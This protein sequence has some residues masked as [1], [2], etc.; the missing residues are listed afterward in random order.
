MTASFFFT[1]LDLLDDYGA[2]AA[3]ISGDAYGP[4]S[5]TQFRLNSKHKS[6][7]A[8]APKAYAVAKGHVLIHPIPGD[9]AHVNLILKPIDQP[10][11]NKGIGLPR[12]KYLIYRQVLKA[13]LI[14][15]GSSPATFVPAG[16]IDMID[17]I[18]STYR[19]KGN[20][21]V[22]VDNFLTSGAPTDL[23]V[24]AFSAKSLPPILTG[25]SIGR[26]D[27]S[28]FSFEVLLDDLG[29]E[30][31]LTLASRNHDVDCIC[32]V[33][34]GSS[35]NAD[36]FTA[37]AKREYVLH[38]MDP[39]AFYGNC[40]LTGLD[41]KKSDGTKVSVNGSNPTKRNALYPIVSKFYNRERAYVD[42]R[43]ENGYS[44]NY[45]CFVDDPVKKN[46]FSIY[47]DQIDLAYIND[48]GT[49]PSPATDYYDSG[50]WPL[51]IV[52]NSRFPP[53]NKKEKNILS[54]RMPSGNNTNATLFFALGIRNEGGVDQP[55]DLRTAVGSPAFVDLPLQPSATAYDSFELVIPN[56]KDAGTTTIIPT[57]S[58][59][60]YIR[61]V[62]PVDLFTEPTA[63]DLQYLDNLFAPALLRDK[64]GGAR[65]STYENEQYVDLTNGDQITKMEYIGNTQIE[66]GASNVTLG[67]YPVYERRRNAGTKPN[68]TIDT[69]LR[70][71]TLE[72]HLSAA[73]AP[74]DVRKPPFVTESLTLPPF[75]PKIA[76]YDRKPML[77]PRWLS[78]DD[79]AGVVLLTIDRNNFQTKVIDAI[80]GPNAASTFSPGFDVYLCIKSQ[81]HRD[82]DDSN[83]ADMSNP[84]IGISQCS[85]FLRGFKL[86]SGNVKVVEVDT[87]IRLYA[88]REPGFTIHTFLRDGD[89]VLQGTSA[90]Q[91][92]SCSFN[93]TD[94]PPASPA[95]LGEE[96]N[97]IS[98]DDMK[99][100]I[101]AL[102]AASSGD[103]ASARLYRYVFSKFIKTKSTPNAKGVFEPEDPDNIELTFSGGALSSAGHPM[104]QGMLLEAANYFTIWKITQGLQRIT[105]KLD[106]THLFDSDTYEGKV[107][108]LTDVLNFLTA[109]YPFF[110]NMVEGLK[111]AAVRSPIQII[112]VDR[113]RKLDLTSVKAFFT[114]IFRDN[115]G[116]SAL[117]AA[118]RTYVQTHDQPG[119]ILSAAKA[120]DALDALDATKQLYVNSMTRCVY[121]GLGGI[122]TEY[123]LLNV[124]IGDGTTTLGLF[125]QGGN[126]SAGPGVFLFH[127]FYDD[128]AQPLR[129]V[130]LTPQPISDGNDH[131]FEVHFGIYGIDNES[132]VK[133][134]ISILNRNGER[135]EGINPVDG[136]KVDAFP[137][138]GESPKSFKSKVPAATGLASWN[139]FTKDLVIEKPMSNGYRSVGISLDSKTDEQTFSIALYKTAGITGGVPFAKSF[140]NLFADD[141]FVL[142]AAK[143]DALW[144]VSEIES[145]KNIVQA[146]GGNATLKLQ[147]MVGGGIGRK[148]A[149]NSVANYTAG[150]RYPEGTLVA[151]NGQFYL[152]LENIAANS[153]FDPAKWLP[154]PAVETDPDFVFAPPASNSPNDPWPRVR[155]DDLQKPAAGSQQETDYAQLRYSYASIIFDSISN[156][157]RISVESYASPLFSRLDESR[158][159]AFEDGSVLAGL[160]P[161]QQTCLTDSTI[162]KQNINS[163]AYVKGAPPAPGE[164]VRDAY[165]PLLSALRCCGLLNALLERIK[166]EAFDDDSTVFN[167]VAPKIDAFKND[168]SVKVNLTPQGPGV[169]KTD[170][171]L[172]K[173]TKIVNNNCP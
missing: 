79:F 18:R 76:Y 135:A 57:Y 6:N 40:Y 148:K 100:F 164:T 122:L 125:G 70:A 56:N 19:G 155:E 169:L 104:H 5:G 159:V 64:T 116:S 23:I 62:A 85:L 73:G 96:L 162:Y 25:A 163:Q 132:T 173:F 78:N 111:A 166:L 11:E 30:P 27:P 107:N 35:S 65:P 160:T 127:Y 13:S 172:I 75:H 151:Y 7:S 22:P 140:E 145:L 92:Y 131:A 51:L 149:T 32:T 24:D 102:Y 165:N 94:P 139:N 115:H 44:F 10:A 43:N 106:D 98:N 168:P 38:F 29:F 130:T 16:T 21:E 67:C 86:D 50:G 93:V 120:K 53:N 133:H 156:E 83:D 52:K 171:N 12:I 37:R 108:K 141:A 74:A 9:D 113:T 63:T 36:Q 26:F 80:K 110:N 81:S 59:V 46:L 117:V 161:N 118:L 121:E 88:K 124:A 54:V 34:Q 128:A 112:Q 158:T 87:Q 89:A 144:D 61:R 99:A 123:T 45:Y 84:A 58:L 152:S 109:Q 39:C 68:P 105:K 101:K 143:Q 28:G 114:N 15:V 103:A 20:S 60:K 42:I 129:R 31:D 90:L 71:A 119:T 136:E 55:I 41:A 134:V 167:R 49:N 8:V 95:T 150:A 72:R 154:Q 69:E 2:S 97:N 17:T 33:P 91:A 170:L 153:G 48:A 4:L 147:R 82:Q 47:A 137:L 126:V 66:L 146:L 77:V 3:Q 157:L 138:I 142:T 14:V 1:D